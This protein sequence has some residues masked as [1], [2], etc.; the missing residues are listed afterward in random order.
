MLSKEPRVSVSAKGILCRPEDLLNPPEDP[1]NRTWCIQY[2]PEGHFIG[3]KASCIGQR[4]SCVG[5]RAF[6]GRAVSW[7]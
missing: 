3:H 4:V 7:V 2:G 6:R 5:Q 1:P